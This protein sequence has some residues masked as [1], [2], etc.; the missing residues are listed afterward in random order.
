MRCSSTVES[1]P[2]LKLREMSECLQ[3][4]AVGEAQ[5]KAAAVG[6][7]TASADV[8]YWFQKMEEP[9]SE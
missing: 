5:Q 9:S 4:D 3:H 7:V 8:Y 6:A 2:P 1:F